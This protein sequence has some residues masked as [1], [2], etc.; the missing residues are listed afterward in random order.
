MNGDEQAVANVLN[1]YE[2]ALNAS[3]TGAAMELYAADA[4][5]MPQN[6]PSSVGIDAVRRV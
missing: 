6:S 4:V 2:R 3:D 5:F 1:A